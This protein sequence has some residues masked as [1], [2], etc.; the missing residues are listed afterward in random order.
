MDLDG[1]ALD[2]LKRQAKRQ[3]RQRMRALRG[4]MPRA[5]LATR[6]A[7]VVE[8]LLTLPEVTAARSI[9]LFWPMEDQGEVDVRALDAQCRARQTPIFYPIIGGD[10]AGAEEPSAGFARVES[11]A[12]LVE[13]GHRFFEPPRGAPLAKPR[14]LDVVLVPALAVSENGHRLGFGSGFYDAALP[15]FCPPARAIAVAFDFQ[16][17]GELPTTDG[18]VACDIIVTDTRVIRVRSPRP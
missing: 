4:A 1:P 14:S 7:A 3:L 10:D 13:A 11:T 16:L 8:R 5:S 9:A 12:E 2:A 18:D 17:L 15:R 6:S